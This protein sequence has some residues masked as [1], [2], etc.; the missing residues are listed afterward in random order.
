MEA[1]RIE[2][3]K[4]IQ[5][6]QVSAE[7]GA[8]LLKAL[9]GDRGNQA[10]RPAPPPPVQQNGAGRWFKVAIEEPSGER[11][12]LS[13]PLQTVPSILRY[14]ARW[15]PEEHRDALQAA[16]EA[17]GTGFRGDLVR[18]EQPSGERVRIWVE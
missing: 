14:V 17:I 6:K 1:E 16:S 4:L 7:D 5:S 2:V 12:N 18:V 10:A 8:R 13:L 15:V 3:L 9:V 11:V